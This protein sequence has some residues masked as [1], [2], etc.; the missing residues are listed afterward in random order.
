MQVL[1]NSQLTDSEKDLEMISILRREYNQL[2]DEKFEIIQSLRTKK[3][4]LYQ[5]INL[6]LQA[7]ELHH[8]ILRT[9]NIINSIAFGWPYELSSDSAIC[10]ELEMKREDDERLKNTKD[11]YEKKIDQINTRLGEKIEELQQY[12]SLVYKANER[13]RFN[14]LAPV[15]KIT[16][17]NIEKQ[18]GEA[19][20]FR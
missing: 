9:D 14:G 19:D 8:H 3:L 10:L 11:L 16:L 18:N 13:L 15:G 7:S 12:R 1:T 17:P 6:R 20:T 4:Y 5:R 2:V